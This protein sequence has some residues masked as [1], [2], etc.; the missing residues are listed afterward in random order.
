MKCPE[1]PLGIVEV[2]EFDADFGLASRQVAGDVIDGES[3][4][5]L[6]G[7]DLLIVDPDAN[8]VVVADGEGV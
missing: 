2:G 6:G 7:V 8:P 3:V 4:V 1:A 5:V